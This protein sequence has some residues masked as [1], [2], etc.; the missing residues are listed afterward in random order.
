V[1][2]TFFDDTAQLAVL[3]VDWQFKKQWD[4]LAEVR[5]LSLPDINQ[6]QRGVLA[7]FYRRLTKNLKAGIGYNFTAFS[8]D[9]TD[10]N[11]KHKG[12]FFN[13]IGTK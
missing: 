5:Q 7:A 13:L 8:D 11:Y 9:L 10:L 2:P 1:Q 3:R 12:I 6:N 4:T